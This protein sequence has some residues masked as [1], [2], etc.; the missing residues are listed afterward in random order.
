MNEQIGGQCAVGTKPE[1]NANDDEQ[2]S[3]VQA[4]FDDRKD[5]FGIWDDSARVLTMEKE[6]F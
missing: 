4:K 2:K 5:N 1:E 3:E 6:V